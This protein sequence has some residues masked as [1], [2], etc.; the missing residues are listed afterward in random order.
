[1]HAFQVLGNNLTL[2]SDI[3]ADEPSQLYASM[4][5]IYPACGFVLR[6]GRD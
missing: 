2:T 3:Q 1:M 6:L 5:R 4:G